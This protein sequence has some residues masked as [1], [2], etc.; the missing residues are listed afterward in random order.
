MLLLRNHSCSCPMHQKTRGIT[1]VVHFLPLS[2]LAPVPISC[3]ATD[4]ASPYFSNR[5][6]W[7]GLVL[8]L[9]DSFQCNT[10][11]GNHLEVYAKSVTSWITTYL[12]KSTTFE[13]GRKCT[14]VRGSNAPNLFLSSSVPS[15]GSRSSSSSPASSYLP[16]T[17]RFSKFFMILRNSSKLK[18]LS[19]SS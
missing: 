17:S 3:S 9:E 13:S 7:A 14:P 18:R 10:S 11:F 15:T 8:P 19:V 2:V 6:T 12:R 1:N 5:Q 16:A 4:E